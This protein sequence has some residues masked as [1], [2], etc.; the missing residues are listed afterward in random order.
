MSIDQTMS[1]ELEQKVRKLGELVKQSQ[2]PPPDDSS[3][4]SQC[5]RL[6]RPML[7]TEIEAGLL[8][9]L[10]RSFDEGYQPHLISLTAT[11]RS[12]RRRGVFADLARHE[13]RVTLH[14]GRWPHTGR[15][16]DPWPVSIGPGWMFS[17]EAFATTD[18]AVITEHGTAAGVQPISPGQTPGRLAEDIIAAIDRNPDTCG[19]GVMPTAVAEVPFADSQ[20]VG[21]PGVLSLIHD[22]DHGTATFQQQLTALVDDRLHAR[23]HERG[24]ETTVFASRRDDLLT[25]THGPLTHH[26]AGLLV[27]SGGH[28]VST[29]TV[30]SIHIHLLPGKC[31]PMAA[32]VRHRQTG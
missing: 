2:Q 15:T 6:C 1:R 27:F 28:Q 12:L 29:D 19:G 13:T 21:G 4:W 3:L 11:A 7:G 23:Q 31:P 30:V 14:A 26:R 17:S 20:L 10:R 24:V 25:R 16:G 8:Q 22:G 5:Q 32:P 9:D 18:T